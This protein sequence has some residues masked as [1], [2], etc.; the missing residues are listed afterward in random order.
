MHANP[1][2]WAGLVDG[3]LA[4][5]PVIRLEISS[6]GPSGERV[7]AILDRQA[8]DGPAGPDYS[9]MIVAATD[10][11]ALKH[12][13]ERLTVHATLLDIVHNAVIVT[14]CSP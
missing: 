2:G 1:E 6:T 11:T 13:Q 7:W 3:L 14:V 10:V 12:A 4:A 9:R 8:D 5:E